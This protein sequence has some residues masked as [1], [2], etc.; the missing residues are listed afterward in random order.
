VDLIAADQMPKIA[1]RVLGLHAT[2]FPVERFAPADRALRACP[3]RA[4]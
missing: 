1:G 3:P 2:P 4:S